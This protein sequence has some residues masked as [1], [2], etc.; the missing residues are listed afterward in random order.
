MRSLA[1]GVKI[2][3]GSSGEPDELTVEAF[4]LNWRSMSSGVTVVPGKSGEPAELVVD[5]FPEEGR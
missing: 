4:P 5:P 3:P 1:E 2:V